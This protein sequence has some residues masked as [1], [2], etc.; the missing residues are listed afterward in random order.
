MRLLT[1]ED[2]SGFLL[3]KYNSQFEATPTIIPLSVRIASLAGFDPHRRQNIRYYPD[4]HNFKLFDVPNRSLPVPKFLGTFRQFI[5]PA[6]VEKLEHDLTAYRIEFITDPQGWTD[7]Y[8]DESGGV[9]S[10][11]TAS[12]TARLY[13]HPKN[14][15]A[16]A[17]LYAPGGNV[18]VAR[19]IVNMAEKWYVRLFGDELLVKKLQELGYRRLA[20]P[21]GE[22]VMYGEAGTRFSDVAIHRPYFDFSCLG[23]D[24]LPD[25]HDPVTGLVDVVINRGVIP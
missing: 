10:C 2:S 21:P 17:V 23:F 20:R 11:M 19:T 8:A 9:N 12:P 6:E 16:L 13:A 4:L 22:F 7:A 18:L 3:H 14:N 5:N 1:R 15:L 24:A 25:T